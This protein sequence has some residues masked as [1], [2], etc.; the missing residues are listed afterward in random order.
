MSSVCEH[1]C[2][3]VW[4]CNCLIFFKVPYLEFSCG[5]TA[6]GVTTAACY[7]AKLAESD[8]VPCSH[9]LLG[10][11]AEERADIDQW[12]EFRQTQILSV[13]FDK[14][15]SVSLLKVSLIRFR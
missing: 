4:Y 1:V 2:T 10:S 15:A 9:Q 7:I 12:L 3:F 13:L 8:N 6:H 14:G 11:C 5:T